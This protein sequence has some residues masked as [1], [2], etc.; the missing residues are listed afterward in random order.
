MKAATLFAIIAALA[1]LAGAYSTTKHQA[2]RDAWRHESGRLLSQIAELEEKLSQTAQGDAEQQPNEPAKRELRAATAKLSALEAQI[3]DRRAEL[4]QLK[5]DRLVADEHAKE[6]LDQLRRQARRLVD[7]ERDL[8]DVQ[9]RHRQMEEHVTGTES[10]IEEMAKT[11][12]SRQEMADALDRKIAELAIRHEVASAKLEVEEA[13]PGAETAQVLKEIKETPKNIQEPAQAAIQQT[14]QASR[15]EEAIADHDRSKGLYQ[16]SALKVVSEPN[17]PSDTAAPNGTTAVDL[18]TQNREASEKWASKQYDLGKQLVSVG[19][20]SSGTRQLNDAVL[21]FHAALGEWP[22]ETHSLRWAATQTD[23]GY[24]LALLGRR[25]SDMGVL[26]DAARASRHALSAIQQ[27]ETPLLWAAAQHNLGVA[28]SGMATIKDDTALWRTAI[29][30]FQ[31]SIEAFEN[32][33]ASVEVK[34]ASRKLEEAQKNLEALSKQ[35]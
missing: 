16:F 6:S 23:L 24:A 7:I 19:E 1:I 31:K 25:Q 17:G 22:R 21:A 15:R 11:V 18:T 32:E 13:T 2:E 14:T 12:A 3:L 33:E 10:K 8:D 30:A 35:P 9:A 26:E 27:D 34:I 20:R 5:S 29:Q 28:L 4:V